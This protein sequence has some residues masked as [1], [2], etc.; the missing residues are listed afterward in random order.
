FDCEDRKPAP[1]T[2]RLS[3][4]TQ[5]GVMV[6]R[7]FAAVVAAAVFVVASARLPVSPATANQPT[8]I[9]QPP[10]TLPNNY[11]DNHPPTKREWPDGPNKSFLQNLQRPD[12]HKHPYRD[13][14]SLTCCDAG[15]T[16]DTKFKVEPVFGPHTEDYP[17]DRWYAWINGEWVLVPPDKIVPDHAPDGRAY[18]FMLAGTIQCFVRPR[19]GL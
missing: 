2:K 19:G 3:I 11:P 17:E 10:D 16:V 14:H 4:T 1:T 13:K 8:D 12:N 7:G 9:A 5:R 6:L 18:L 15:D